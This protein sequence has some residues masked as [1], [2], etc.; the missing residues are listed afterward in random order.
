MRTEGD[1]ERAVRAW[2]TQGSERL[3]DPALD[4]AL[5][6]I[7]ITPQVRAGWLA[8]TFQIMSSNLLPFGAAVVI[9][10]AAIVGRGLLPGNVGGPGPTPTPT[11]TPVPLVSGSFTAPLG[12]GTTIDIQATG[13]GANVSGVMGVSE[14]N[15]RFSVALNC[16]RPA[17]NR[18]ILIG[19]DVTDSTHDAATEG[20]RV[21]IALQP[22]TPVKAVL[23]FEDPPAAAS[24]PAFLESVP[25]EI[26]NDLQ[27]VEGRVEIGPQ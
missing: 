20:S 4:A 18:L 19:G 1:L 27:P 24:C 16:T 13:G 9:I 5:H 15:G 6:Q 14:D 7:S 10:A 22:G 17:D 11:P 3:P 8:R 26:V 21:A 23:W 25:A 12:S 2:V